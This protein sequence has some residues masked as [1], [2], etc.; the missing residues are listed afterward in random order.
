MFLSCEPIAR[1]QCFLDLKYKANLKSVQPKD[2]KKMGLFK[3]NDSAEAGRN[4][5]MISIHTTPQIGLDQTGA[6][7][8]NHTNSTVLIL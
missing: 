5:N 4:V 1:A 8:F 6:K 7:C 2:H 3:R